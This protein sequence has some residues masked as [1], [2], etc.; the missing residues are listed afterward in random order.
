MN[1]FH[2]YDYLGIQGIKSE[3][4]LEAEG[5]IVFKHGVSGK[6]VLDIGA[7]DGWFS[8]KAESLEASEVTA[9]DWFCWG[10]PGWGSKESF[11]FV[12]A[13]K[14]SS[15]KELECDIPDL[16]PQR[17]GQF[18]VVLLLGVL[19]HA[20][21][22]LS[23]LD[24]AQA[25]TRNHLIIESRTM[26]GNKPV[27]KYWRNADLN[28]DPTNYWTPTV[29][30]VKDMLSEFGFS[31]YEIHLTPNSHLSLKMNQIIFNPLVKNLLYVL[32]PTSIPVR[33]II[34]AWKE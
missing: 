3:A 27:A 7:W 23:I 26:Y 13:Q 32:S 10:G 19:Y 22:M 5:D 12:R 31:R 11:D 4:Q 24:K 8:F 34:H 17:H 14:G 28:G 15:V 20:R 18:D 25:M 21:D 6:S 16:D 1:Y 9:C 33:H 29:T 2:S 30:C